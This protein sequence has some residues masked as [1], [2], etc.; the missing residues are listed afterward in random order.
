MHSRDSTSSYIEIEYESYYENSILEFFVHS[1]G[2]HSYVMACLS[3][4]GWKSERN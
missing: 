4:V 3:W 2:I 1:L